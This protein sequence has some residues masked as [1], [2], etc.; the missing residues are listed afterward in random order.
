MLH[1]AKQVVVLSGIEQKP[2]LSTWTVDLIS[3]SVK[4]SEK[5]YLKKV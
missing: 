4:S 2:C 5:K 3:V 1:G